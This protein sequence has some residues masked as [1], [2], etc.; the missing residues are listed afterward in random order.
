[1]QFITLFLKGT[2]NKMITDDKIAK[3]QL[4]LC[5]L[6]LEQRHLN[7][8]MAKLLRNGKTIDFF[9]A[10]QIKSMK[11]GLADKISKVEASIDPNII[12]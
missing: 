10:R 9:Q 4:L 7:T 2:H 3:L 12:A 5:E 8:D 6:K 11:K 1:M